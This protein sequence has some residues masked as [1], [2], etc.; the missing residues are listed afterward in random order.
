MKNSYLLRDVCEVRYGKALQK[1][2]RI[3]GDIPVYSSG[4]ITGS[5]NFALVNE[6][7]IIIGRK[8]TIG[9]VY[10]SDKPFYPIDTAFYMKSSEVKCNLKFFYYLLQ[11]LDLKSLNS[12]SAVPGLNRTN[13]LNRQIA[14]PP[15]DEQ[16]RIAGILS[17][18]DDKIELNRKMNETLEAIALAIFKEWFVDFRYPGATGD[19]VESELG[20]IPRGWRVGELG[21]FGKIVCGKTPPKQI[22]DYYGGE[23][24]FI[25]I[26]DMHSQLYIISTNDSLTFDGAASQPTKYIPEESVIVSCIATVGLVSITAKRSQTNQQINAILPIKSFFTFYLYH[27]LIGLKFELIRMGSAGSATL[28]VNTSDFSRIQCIIPTFG[29]VELFDALI[30]PMFENILCNQM[31][32]KTLAQTRDALLNYFLV[33]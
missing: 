16:K 23:I 15:L 17:A 27:M 2:I 9:T 33:N 28:N 4:G 21:D 18:F 31:E 3:E 10:F 14:V 8:G 13:L 1:E 11:T 5:H 7:G 25:K 12:D 6:P 32:N 26:P 29:V 19:L 22:S 24:P 30:R 20:P